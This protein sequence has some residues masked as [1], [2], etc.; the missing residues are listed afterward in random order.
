MFSYFL[1]DEYLPAIEGRYFPVVAQA[2]LVSHDPSPPP[3]YR[4][5]WQA[6]AVK[7]RDCEYISGSLSWY[8]GPLN[9]RRTQVPARFLDPPQVRGVGL[10]QWEAL[11]IDLVPE[12][13]VTNSHARVRHQ[14]PWRFWETETVFYASQNEAAP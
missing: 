14:C 1:V 5:V 8:L 12:S 9:G 3:P 4:A 11:Q 2:R 7:L 13:V 10:L 6:T